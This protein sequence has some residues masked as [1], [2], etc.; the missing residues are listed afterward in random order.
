[1]P[2]E[3]EPVTYAAHLEPVVLARCVHCHTTEEPEAD[4]V[5]EPGMGYDDLVG[6]MST[7][8]T[9]MPLVTPGDPEA[10]YLWLKVDHRVDIGQGMPRTFLGAKRLPEPEVERFLRWIEDGALP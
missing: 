8:V 4:L 7:Q 10:S 2:P 3:G 5:L 6:P 1:M 9:T